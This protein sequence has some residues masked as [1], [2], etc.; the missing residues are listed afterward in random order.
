MIAR[1]A[2]ASRVPLVIVAGG[3][4]TVSEAARELVQQDCTL[5]IIPLGTFN[6]IAR[7]LDLPPE[8]AG[9]CE[10]IGRSRTHRIDVGVLNDVHYFFEAAGIGLEA[11]LFPVG[12]EIKAG[13]WTR[14]FDAARLA[15]RYRARPVII[16]FD[17]TVADAYVPTD[18]AWRPSSRARTFHQVR[19]RALMTNVAN[20]PYYGGNFTIA[21]MARFDD[22][23]LTVSV[24]RN[25]SKLDLLRHFRS[26]SGGRHRYSPRVEQ[27]RAAAVRISSSLP[28]PVHADGE[29]VGHLP[30]TFGL[31]RAA[32]QVCCP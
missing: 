17:R 30:A 28:L 25:F 2:V 1:E 8:I 16:E 13:R 15:F 5:G 14:L 6:N 32:L 31:V 22:G 10:L 24:Y 3:D 18:Q 27:Y 4:G 7:G 23:L 19:C 26:I 29:P 12:E 9:A 21:P 11:E 20:G